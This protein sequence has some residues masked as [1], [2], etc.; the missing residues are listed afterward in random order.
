[1]LDGLSTTKRFTLIIVGSLVLYSLSTGVS[2]LVFSASQGK[3]VTFE[4]PLADLANVSIGGKK[5]DVAGAKTETCPLNGSLHPKKTKLDW[6]Q[7]RPLGIMIENHVEARPQVGL[8]FAD[9][10][11]EAVAEGGITRFLAI[12]YCVPDESITV[13]PVRSAR[14]YFVKW[15]SEY[16]ASPLYAH[17]GGANMPG[18]ADALG[19]IREYGWEGY[20]GLNQFSIGFPT[21]WR[22]Y[23]RGVATEHTMYADIQKLW[24]VAKKRGLTN[25]DKKGNKWEAG[26]VS[27]KFKDDPERNARPASSSATF[28]FWGDET[29]EV[30][31]KYN[32]EDNRYYRFNAGSSHLDAASGQ[33]VKASTVVVQYVPESRA[34][35]GYPGD[36]HLVYGLTGEAP[37]KILRDGQ[38]IDA[39]WHKASR[40]DRTR[41]KDKSGK[42]IEFTRGPI[43]IHT[44]P[45]GNTSL[46]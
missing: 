46:Q 27:W 36:V 28:D 35:D 18:P 39:K 37:A 12:Y 8:T 4:S 17:V 1:M 41:Y 38:T 23:S 33:Q 20:N 10:V 9:I 16:G 40:Q 31:W 21:F 7:R 44:L 24:E 42:E 30:S 6:E 29:F 22:D 14:E 11:Y 3:K 2:Y 15:I 32:P 13:G 19:Q 26:F 43:W 34:N 45:K 25:V 5:L